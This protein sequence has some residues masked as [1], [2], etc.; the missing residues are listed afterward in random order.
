MSLRNPLSLLQ[1]PKPVWENPELSIGPFRGVV[2]GGLKYWDAQGPAQEAYDQMCTDIQQVLNSSCGPVRCSSAVVYDIYMVGRDASTAVPH[3]MFSCKQPKS[4][5]QA[6]AAVRESGIVQRWPGIELGHWEYPPHILNL[7]LL[8]SSGGQGYLDLDDSA[9]YYFLRPIP[10]PDKPTET[11]AI[12]FLLSRSEDSR[13]A[14]IG[15]VTEYNGRL[16]YVVPQHIFSAPESTPDLAEWDPELENDSDCEFG[17]FAGDDQISAEEAEFTSQYSISPPSS[18]VD[19][20]SESYDE[21]VFSEGEVDGWSL[22]GPDESQT[23]TKNDDEYDETLLPLPLPKGE[24]VKRLAKDPNVSSQDLDYALLEV[25]ADDELGA[26]LPLLSKANV[27]KVSPGGAAVITVTGAGHILHGRL[28]GRVSYVRSPNAATFRKAWVVDLNGPLHQ[29][30]CGSIVRDRET[31][32]IYGH[33]FLGSVQSRVAYVMPAATI[34]RDA[35]T[36]LERMD[37]GIIVYISLLIQVVCARIW[38]SIVQLLP[39][40]PAAATLRVA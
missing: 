38:A 18:E 23:A 11:L 10:D 13:Q 8:A 9:S 3:I 33:I 20:D 2:K 5:K 22:P 21:D 26:G 36:T 30:D 15:S 31:G 32:D 34:L 4:R 29:G 37:Q 1:R 24:P 25:D 28:S 19:S 17:A 12:E 27:S 7:R 39:P 40:T 14:T 16:F 6:V 35:R